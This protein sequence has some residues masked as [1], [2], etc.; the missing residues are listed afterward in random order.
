MITSENGRI[1]DLDNWTIT[2][3]DLFLVD[4]GTSGFTSY[5]VDRG[6]FKPADIIE[7]FE[8][9]PGLEE[10]TH[11]AHHI[12]THHSMGAFM[13]ATDESQLNDRGYISNYFLMLVVDT[14]PPFNWVAR[15]AFRGRI[16]AQEKTRLEFVNN[17]DG[18]PSFDLEGYESREVLCVMECKVVKEEMTDLVVDP[19]LERYKKVVASSNTSSTSISGYRAPIVPS[20]PSTSG[21]THSGWAQKEAEGQER[22]TRTQGLGHK[23]IMHMSEEEWKKF[24]Q[25]VIKEDYLF[26][27]RHARA[28][29]NALIGFVPVTQAKMSFEDPLQG[30]A[31]FAREKP[32]ERVTD[33]ISNVGYEFSDWM[34]ANFPEATTAEVLKM[35]EVLE[36]YLKPYSY[37]DLMDR[38]H[39][40]IS[41]EIQDIKD[42]LN[43][44]EEAK[45]R[46]PTTGMGVWNGNADY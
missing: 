1:T 43:W 30:V 24:N 19:F 44:E 23:R 12:H 40:A 27:Q 10:G 26:E 31:R 39:T 4:V 21:S 37:S 3:E 22:F 33:I 18:Y 36:S 15:V 45:Q 2:A 8:A 25:R 6:S 28:F 16:A 11:K 20:G 46:V 41:S 17:L 14:V 32:L 9:F 42:Q 34:E 35:L 38:L 5:E 13:S 29:I 7:L